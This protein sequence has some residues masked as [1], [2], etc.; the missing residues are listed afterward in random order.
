MFH[1][2]SYGTYFYIF[3]LCLCVYFDALYIGFSTNFRMEHISIL[4]FFASVCILIPSILDFRLIF[5]WNIFLYFHFVRLC[6]FLCP[7]YWIFHIFLPSGAGCVAWH[8]WA[9]D[10][11]F[12][13]NSLFEKQLSQGF[14]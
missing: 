2:F 13:S 8:C 7:L 4:S 3:I 6:V 5:T 12:Y 1:Q 9:A 11:H 14:L 10:Q